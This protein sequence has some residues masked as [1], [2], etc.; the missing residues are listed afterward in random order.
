MAE[1][2]EA[3]RS[4]LPRGPVALVSVLAT[5]GSAPRGAGTKML[6]SAE[7]IFG[8]IGGGKLEFTAIAQARAALGRAPGSW[9]VQD[10]PLGPLL[11]QCC[12]GRVRLLVEHLDPASCG[13]LQAEP[14]ETLVAR[15]AE[16]RIERAYGGRLATSLPP[17]R[18]ALPGAG[19]SFVEP[20][21]ITSRPVLLFGGGH[22]GQAMARVFAGL[23]LSL[24]WFDVRPELAG[25]PGLVCCTA[26]EMQALLAEAPPE[27]AVLVL[28]HDHL[29]DYALVRAALSGPAGFVGMIGSGTKRAR[30]LARLAADGVDP[31]RLTC[32]IGLAGV[33]GKQ[34]EVIAVSVAAQLLSL[35]GG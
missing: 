21:E 10:Y 18:G 16:G 19:A 22:V 23:P 33:A 30:F 12:G 2:I 1:W 14:G 26:E 6:V 4:W 29:L 3:L 24:G 32:P 35:E 5:E 15:L 20:V 25:L 7:A 13:F 34:P 31:A 17:A 9:A 27:A 8:T 28:T 11:G